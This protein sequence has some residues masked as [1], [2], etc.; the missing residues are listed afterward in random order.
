MG[1]PTWTGTPTYA[2]WF[3]RV[4]AYLLRSLMPL[5]VIIVGW[6]IAVVI[7]DVG[8][9]VLVLAY[10]VGFVMTIRLMIQ[11]AHLGY[12]AADAI[13]GTNLVRD[14]TGVPMGSGWSVFGRAILHIVD[15][16]PFYLGFLWPIWD[17]KKQT[18]ADKI[19]KTVVVER[20]QVHSAG[21][22]FRNALE[23]WKPVLK[24]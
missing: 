15:T 11:R 19:V 2:G 5:P 17:A 3:Q 10:V 1:V 24:S 12:D 18:F 9:L 8:V 4:G 23:L 13:V 6:I 16:L 20:P 21:V 22:L 7:G 14:A